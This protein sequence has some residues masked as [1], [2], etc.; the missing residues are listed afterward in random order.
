[1]KWSVENKKNGMEN[2]QAA[3]VM[4]YRHLDPK[5]KNAYR[6]HFI[7]PN[8]LSFQSLIRSLQ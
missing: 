7:H 3:S 4:N 8:L 2:E 5:L 6:I 1:M